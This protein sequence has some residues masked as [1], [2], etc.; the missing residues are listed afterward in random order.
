MAR[1]TAYILGGAAGAY[2]LAALGLFII[3]RDIL[4][5]PTPVLAHDYP[6]EVVAS[7]GDQVRIIVLNEGQ[8]QALIYFGGNGESALR[9]AQW[10]EGM[11]PQHTVYLMNYPGF[12]GSEGEPTE[13]ALFA[14]ADVL[15]EQVVKRHNRISIAGRSLGTGVS[16]YLASKHDQID[17]LVLITPYDSIEQLAAARYPMFP[18]HWLLLDRFDSAKRAPKITA[19]TLLVAA[20]DDRVVPFGSTKRLLQA[21][22]P[23]LASLVVIPN[24]NHVNISDTDAYR[25]NL[26]R[27]IGLTPN[28]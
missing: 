2:L 3:Q 12:G 4:Y 17:R 1:I 15:F 26:R 20:S 9:S 28:G 11:L 27:F 22:S 13:A 10:M 24:T 25:E 8:E 19:P 14:A 5:H 18:V 7:G 16:A 6:V 21:F 23:G